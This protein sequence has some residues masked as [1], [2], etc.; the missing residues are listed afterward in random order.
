LFLVGFLTVKRN[1]FIRLATNLKLCG[2]Y[3]HVFRFNAQNYEK[4][5]I[6]HLK[7]DLQV[8]HSDQKT[9]LT[10]GQ[11]CTL[12]RYL[13]QMFQGQFQEKPEIQIFNRVK[14]TVSFSSR[15]KSCMEKKVR[16]FVQRSLGYHGKFQL[17][18]FPSILI[19]I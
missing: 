17:H 13:T 1:Q 16:F 15:L 14:N 18:P 19:S 9:I 12:R 4:H 3:V 2:W 11:K 6:V 8:G 10:I 7:I 5:S